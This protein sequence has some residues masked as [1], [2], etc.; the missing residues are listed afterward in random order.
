MVLSWYLLYAMTPEDI[1]AL[2]LRAHAVRISVNPPFTWTSGMKAPIYCDNRL[3]LGCAGERSEIVDAL[4]EAVRSLK[5]Q[6][7]VIAG[8]ATAGIG[9][10]ALV[11]DRLALPMAYIRHKSKEYGTGKSIEGG[12]REGSNV[13]VIE[14]L[15]STGGSAMRS[16]EILRTE[17]KCAVSDVVAIFTYGF[18]KAEKL[19]EEGNVAL[20]ALSS[21]ATLLEVANKQGKLSPGDLA[22]ASAFAKDPD[23]WASKL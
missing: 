13:V 12:Y 2:L 15:I 8:T 1:A 19:A 3:L 11:A 7:D 5:K 21:F 4:T 16:V 23:G 17:G 10:A 20:H 18:P 6:P 14:D 9:W 22:L